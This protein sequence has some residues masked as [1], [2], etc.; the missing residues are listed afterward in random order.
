MA[1]I[2]LLK[3]YANTGVRIYAICKA[4]RIRPKQPAKTAWTSRSRRGY[5]NDL[6]M[7]SWTNGKNDNGAVANARL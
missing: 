7:V 2:Q 6:Q 1:C 5:T 3:D 4:T